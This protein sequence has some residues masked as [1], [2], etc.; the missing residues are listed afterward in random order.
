MQG[1]THLAMGILVQKT[2]K[3]VQVRSIYLYYFFVAFIAILSH[4]ILDKLARFTYH[5]PMPLPE[6]EFWVSYHSII[7]FLTIFIFYKMWKGYKIGLVFSILPDFD[8]I[9][10]HLSNIFS[11]QIPFYKE[12][13]LHEFFF[14]FLDWLPPFSFLLSLPNWNLERLAVITEFGVLAFIC[15]LIMGKRKKLLTLEEKPVESR[16]R[17][18]TRDWTN[19][20]SIY[21]SAMDH[22]SK[23]RTS[24]QSL[25]TSLEAALFSLVITLY[26][27]K[28][29]D[30]LWLFPIGGI[31]LCFFLG[32]ACEFR[33]RNIDV[34]RVR[35][36]EVVKGTDLE[37]AFKEAKYRWIPFGKAGFWGEYLFGHWF[38]RIF[39]TSIITI[40]VIA[41]FYFP[42]P[43]IL[44]PLSIWAACFWI[45]YVFGLIEPKGRI[46]PY[47]IKHE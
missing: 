39:V 5:P 22:E 2:M 6:D 21:L 14:S 24:Y 25:L 7:V 9:V 27:L 10:L 16:E 18:N 13:L 12:P 8:W 38:E 29:I 43:F 26:Q 23:I 44:R 41:V 11:I 40:W 4:G 17:I 36:V 37:E 45:I 35:I 42:T 20:L 3:K 28:L 15:I 30:L 32:I 34:W 31:A 1:P 33:A 19:K 46:I 47:I